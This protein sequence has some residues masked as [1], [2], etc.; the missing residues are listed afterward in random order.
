MQKPN[1]RLFKRKGPWTLW[2]DWTIKLQQIRNAP[3]HQKQSGNWAQ[4]GLILHLASAPPSMLAFSTCKEMQS[5]T[6]L[7]LCLFI[8]QSATL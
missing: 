8:P 2:K 3:E 5:P 6:A 4:Q 1:S 7:D